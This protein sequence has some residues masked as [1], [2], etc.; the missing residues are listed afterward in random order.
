MAEPWPR[1]KNRTRERQ[2]WRR[3]GS[4]LP[5]Q[6]ELGLGLGANPNRKG[7]KKKKNRAATLLLLEV[8]DD[9]EPGR[10]GSVEPNPVQSGSGS[11][12]KKKER[13]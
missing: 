2:G 9:P 10:F 8:G 11:N 12:E 4:S 13:K 5:C 1:I 6:T 7:K 3:Q